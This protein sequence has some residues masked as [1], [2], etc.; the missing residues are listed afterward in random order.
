[1]SQQSLRADIVKTIQE[2]ALI[3]TNII[4]DCCLILAWVLAAFIVNKYLVPLL[5][6]K[7]FDLFLL[8]VF[9]WSSGILTLGIVLAYA[10]RDFLVIIFRVQ[11]EIK[12]EK[13]RYA[14]SANKRT[15]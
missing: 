4:L 6:E 1:M 10:I 5:D 9:Q 11:A 13:E 12:V 7:G 15:P 2:R 3:V 14:K 8:N